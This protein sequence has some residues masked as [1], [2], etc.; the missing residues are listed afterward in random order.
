M[1]QMVEIYKQLELKKNQQIQEAVAKE[2]LQKLNAM[3]IH[4]ASADTR[5]NGSS[6]SRIPV[7]LLQ[8]CALSEQKGSLG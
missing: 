3:D 4:I 6:N 7:P 5:G 8:Q 2:T 1:A